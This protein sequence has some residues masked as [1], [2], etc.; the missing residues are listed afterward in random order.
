M[1]SSNN[2]KKTGASSNPIKRSARLNSPADS[3][4][5]FEL[6]P[7][8]P[9]ADVSNKKQK[10]NSKVKPQDS[11]DSM[12]GSFDS[13]KSTDLREDQE[14]DE[15]YFP[16]D[17]DV[18][19][20]E[21]SDMNSKIWIAKVLEV[22]NYS[23]ESGLQKQ[24]DLLMA[25]MFA[26]KSKFEF[27]SPRMMGLL[28]D[29]ENTPFL[30]LGFDNVLKA[31]TSAMKSDQVEGVENFLTSPDTHV[32]VAKTSNLSRGENDVQTML[33]CIAPTYSAS[34]NN[35]KILVGLLYTKCPDWDSAKVKLRV[36]IQ[37]N[38]ASIPILM[39]NPRRLDA[40]GSPK[41]FPRMALTSTHCSD[42]R[43]DNFLSSA[44]VQASKLNQSEQPVDFLASLY[45]YADCCLELDLAKEARLLIQFSL[46]AI[47]VSEIKGISFPQFVSVIEE[48]WHEAYVSRTKNEYPDWCPVKLNSEK[49]PKLR[50]MHE[51]S[52]YGSGL[53]T[54]KISNSRMHDRDG[55][56][57][58]PNARAGL[59]QDMRSRVEASFKH[60]F[61]VKKYCR[62]FNSKNSKCQKADENDCTFLHACHH[63][64]K[65]NPSSFEE[66]HHGAQ[67]CPKL[68]LH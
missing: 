8:L 66:V 15:Y 63:C 46:F 7:L 10:L 57:N 39:F 14:D 58:S 27:P 9:K 23:E 45:H 22:I 31:V 41:I 52:A 50:T 60:I 6:P 42:H 24:K 68:T 18:T 37:K 65:K 21:V 47:Q 61:D 34:A 26:W 59:G 4:K 16:D 2:K 13:A 33:N 67:D 44:I 54:L 19:H 12:V 32:E 55:Y 5:L 35:P 49:I 43:V 17:S 3:E 48:C 11:G 25:A 51:R 1:S 53:G 40:K 38:F 36:D 64:A 62:Y 28:E 30:K 29:L 20:R 56:L